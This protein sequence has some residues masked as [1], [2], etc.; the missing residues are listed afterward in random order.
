MPAR[1][2]A[3][4]TACWNVRN[5]FASAANPGFFRTT[6][7]S[8]FSNEIFSTA[9]LVVQTSEVMLQSAFILYRSYRNWPG[10]EKLSWVYW[11][12]EFRCTEEFELHNP[13]LQLVLRR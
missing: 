6:D 12:I 5:E 4:V 2:Q 8:R 3:S 13:Y 7:N 1:A 9:L 11:T 10:F